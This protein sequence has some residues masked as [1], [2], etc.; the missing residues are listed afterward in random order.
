MVVGHQHTQTVEVSAV[1]AVDESENHGG[2]WSGWR[3]IA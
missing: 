1:D 2:W 3:T